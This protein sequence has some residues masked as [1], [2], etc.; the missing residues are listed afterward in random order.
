LTDSVSTPRGVIAVE[1][2]WQ[3]DDLNKSAYSWHPNPA[4]SDL[5]FGLDDPVSMA[6]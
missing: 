6:E 3:S 5:G 1:R 2:A 4:W